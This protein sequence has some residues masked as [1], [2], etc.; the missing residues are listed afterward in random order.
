M[1]SLHLQPLLGCLLDIKSWMGANS[2]KMNEDRD[3]EKILSGILTNALGPLA[4]NFR[5][6]VRN[7]GVILDGPAEPITV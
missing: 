4:S 1:I 7:V 2:L 5:S 3:Y 6:S